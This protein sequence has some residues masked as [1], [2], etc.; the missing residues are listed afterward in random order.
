MAKVWHDI[1]WKGKREQLLE[2]DLLEQVLQIVI[3]DASPLSGPFH[4]LAIV[5]DS[6]RNE[7]NSAVT[8]C[9]GTSVKVSNF[10]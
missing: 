6:S 9:I 1:D 2:I 5:M 8:M 10:S 4:I 7:Q 3:I